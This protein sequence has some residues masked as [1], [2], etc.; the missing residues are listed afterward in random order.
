MADRSLEDD[1]ALEWLEEQE[2][3]GGDDSEKLVETTQRN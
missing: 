1:G 2:E 3:G